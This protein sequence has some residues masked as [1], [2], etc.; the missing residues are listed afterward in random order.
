MGAAMDEP[1]SERDFV[2]LLEM[3]T[4]RLCNM[5]NKVFKLGLE[6]L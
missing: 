2:G 1:G 6:A 3:G 4:T 5:R